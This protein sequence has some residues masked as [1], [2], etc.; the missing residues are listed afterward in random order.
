MSIEVN[1][2]VKSYGKQKALKNVSFTL[3][4]G[5]I[6][7]FIGPNGAGKTT[8]MKIITGLLTPD[9]G[10][11]SIL[12]TNV[13]E[14]PLLTKKHIGYL[15]EN[16][17]L[18][19]DMYVREYLA[20]ISKIYC[21]GKDTSKNVSEII[22]RTGLSKEQ[23]KKIEELSKGYKQRVG[24]AQALIHD[25][26]ILILD[27]PTT[28]LDPNQLEEIRGL[29]KDLGRDKTVVLSTHIMQEVEAICDRI[30]II[31]NGE[32]TA[33]EE[34]QNLIKQSGSESL[35]IS[36]EFTEEINLSILKT[37]KGIK[38]TRKLTP[39]RYILSCT[40]DIRKDIFTFAVEN[41]HQ[42]IEIRILDK[43]LESIF[44]EL[45]KN[46]TIDN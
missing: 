29:I 25:P 35:E 23:H 44:R 22:E 31:N 1:N 19:T 26:E 20:Y 5:E 21:S 10:S 16:N 8:T 30:I 4:P 34:S 14:N 13:K 3:N 18:Y 38:A 46:K 41:N 6:T 7:G 40:E 45:T 11:V 28:G 37:I 24:L 2:V 17:P 36:V 43:N 9:S 33:N 32:I 39:T 27:E 15:P 42:L 12:G